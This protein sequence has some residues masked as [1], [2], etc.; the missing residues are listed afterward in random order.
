MSGVRDFFLCF[1]NYFLN[2]YTSSQYFKDIHGFHLPTRRLLTTSLYGIGRVTTERDSE[3][4]F[5][6]SIYR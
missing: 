6:L 3:K 2:Y 4:P 5:S 1:F